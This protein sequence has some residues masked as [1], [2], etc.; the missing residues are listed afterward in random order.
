M[1]S[2]YKIWFTLIAVLVIAKSVA[3]WT[4]PVNISNT[5]IS[6]YRC[7]IA[8]EKDGKIHAVWTERYGIDQDHD[9]YYAYSENSGYSW[10]TPENICDNS[11][12]CTAPDVV[13]DSNNVAHIVWM[14]LSIGDIFWTH[15]L[16]DTWATPVDISNQPGSEEK[17]VAV[18]D[19]QGKIW[20][21]WR[22]YLEDC[23]Y[24]VY[25]GAS[26]CSPQNLTNDTV[27]TG[28]AR[29]TVDTIGKLHAIW[30]RSPDGIHTYIQYSKYNG[31][32]WTD[33]EELP[34]L[35]GNATGP[36]IETDS[37]QRPWVIWRE[38][39]GP[40]FHRLYYSH[41]DSAGWSFPSLIAD[42]DRFTHNFVFDSG[43]CLHLFWSGKVNATDYSH[44]YYS[45]FDGA[46]WSTAFDLSDTLAQSAGWPDAIVDSEDRLH[47]IWSESLEWGIDKMDVFYS[48]DDLTGVE[49]NSEDWYSKHISRQ[50]FPNPFSSRTTIY[51]T[52]P[53]AAGV[54]L[55]ISD[56]AGR[57][58]VDLDIGYKSKGSHALSVPAKVLKKEGSAYA[59]VYFY[60]IEADGEVIARGK[61]VFLR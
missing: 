59:G 46:S 3:A 52:V 56:L 48:K 44:L 16:G 51:Y 27:P 9:I 18:A 17:P 13:V 10:S 57:I 40:D 49:E 35:F 23:Y 50:N 15:Q 38:Y 21:F 7:A 45:F 29:A 33:A 24:V 5:P 26:W 47:L 55:L 11:L 4:E 6:S 25:D 8:T 39:T 41:R 42:E 30:I 34:T 12:I 43:D 14:N 20:V 32:N 60:R 1:V 19:K 28:G 53:E 61:L 31:E 37:K 54:T 2:G 22:Q 58:L 36:K